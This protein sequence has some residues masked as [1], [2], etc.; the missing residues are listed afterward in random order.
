MKRVYESMLREHFASNRQMAFVS[1]PRQVGKTSLAESVLPNATLLNYDNQSHARIIAAGPERVAEFADL[2][3]PLKLAQGIV[4]DELHKFPKWKG[5]LKGFF[6]V[7]GKG[8]K[9]VVTG[10]ARLDI[11]KRGGDSLMGRYFPFRIHP[12]GI[13][14]L[15]GGDLD[16]EGFLRKPGKPSREALDQLLQ[17]GGFPEP[18]LKGNARFRNQWNRTRLERLFRED[19]RDFSRVQD[20]IGIRSLASLV[21]S[22]VCGGVN[23]AAMASDLSV[24][25]DTAKSWLGILE[26]VYYSY[27]ITPWFRNVANSIRK[28]P[29]VYLWDWSALPDGGAKNENFIA[30]QLLKAVHWWTDTGLGDF[31]LHYLRD[32]TGREV[33]FVIARDGVPFMLVECKSSMKET[34]SRTLEEVQRQ[35]AVKYAFQVGMDGESSDLNPFDYE[36][37]AIKVSALDLLKMLI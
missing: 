24:A 20:I 34:L 17:L 4:F 27:S 25:P 30:S 9:V 18:F 12:L 37:M 7:H 16:T 8:L 3:N 5:L 10:S 26:S 6:D 2:A 22:R 21:A 31:S 13:G 15:E 36:G 29:K 19:I 32:K 23:Y 35:M 14:E 1:G 11:Y 33:D 28:Q